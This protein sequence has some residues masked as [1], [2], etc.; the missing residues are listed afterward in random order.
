MCPQHR[1]IPLTTEPAATSCASSLQMSKGNCFAPTEGSHQW[2]W[3]WFDSAAPKGPT[4]RGGSS[5]TLTQHACVAQGQ[6]MAPAEVVPN[7]WLKRQL[8]SEGT[9]H[10]LPAV[11]RAQNNLEGI[12]GVCGELL[13]DTQTDAF[14][15]LRWVLLDHVTTEKGTAS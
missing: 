9:A 12:P 8:R 6:L 3:F 14:S 4:W 10:L 7:R 15:G 2:S 1:V 13:P 5:E 11:S